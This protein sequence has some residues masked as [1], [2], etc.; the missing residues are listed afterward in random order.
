MPS[1]ATRCASCRAEKDL[2][3]SFAQYD[4]VKAG[5]RKLPCACGA[6]TEIQFSPG[7]IGFSFKDGESGGWAS[8]AMKENAYRADRS[9]VM[10]RRERDHVFKNKLVPNYQGEETG[11][12]R[13]AQN[14]ALKEGGDLSASTYEPLVQQEQTP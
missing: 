11:T 3:L 9:Q 8:K 10:A 6:E 4:E 12:W 13:E 7:H 1:Y 5:T 2:R 14:E